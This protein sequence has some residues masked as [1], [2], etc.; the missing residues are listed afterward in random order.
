MCSEITTVTGN[1]E[2]C[3]HHTRTGKAPRRSQSEGLSGGLPGGGWHGSS[4]FGGGSPPTSPFRE[5]PQIQRKTTGM[6]DSPPTPRV[7]T[8][9]AEKALLFSPLPFSFRKSLKKCD[10]IE[11]ERRKERREGGQERREGGRKERE[12]GRERE[13]LPHVGTVI[14]HVD[15]NTSAKTGSR[16]M[17]PREAL[18]ARS[19]APGNYRGL[20]IS[21]GREKKSPAPDLVFF[22]FLNR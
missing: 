10:K 18:R 21:L 9:R 6:E 1:G 7:I 8:M 11:R 5:Q 16:E 13:A 19:G 22:F 3:P 20:V 17:L 2:G 12:R 14:I 15:V 4:G